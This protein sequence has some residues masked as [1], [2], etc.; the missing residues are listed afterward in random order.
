MSSRLFVGLICVALFG[1]M[2]LGCSHMKIGGSREVTKNTQ[3]RSISEIEIQQDLQRFA[4]Q[5]F[6]RNTEAADEASS[7]LGTE[8]QH[9]MLKRILLY[10]SSALDIVSGKITA[11]NLLDMMVFTTLTR[12]A[13]EH[14]FMPGMFGAAGKPLLDSLRRSELQIWRIGEGILTNDQL[15]RLRALITQWKKDNPDQYRVEMVRLSQF[16]R[17]AGNLAEKEEDDARG[18]MAGVRSATQTADAAVLLGERSMFFAQRAPF[19]FRLQARVGAYEITRDGIRQLAGQAK[20]LDRTEQLLDR[21]NTII[22]KSSTLMERTGE[23]EPMLQELSE[24]TQNATVVTREARLLNASLTPLAERLAPLLEERVDAQGKPV[25]AVESVLDSSNELSSR[26]FDLV[27]EL[28]GLL[29]NGRG[30]QRFG[31]LRSELDTELRRIFGYLALLGA[32]WATFFWGGYYLVR[33]RMDERAAR[34]PRAPGG[35]L[36]RGARPSAG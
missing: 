22:D 15:T 23:L 12:D 7:E 6:D 24:L 29:P 35:S 13:Y 32:A 36:P 30:D 9:E 4:G 10:D 2:A 31:V 16:S 25:L 3:G 5:Y 20:L 19:L 8:L 18:L 17:V 34:G 11:I 33:R 27:H 1:G 28:R 14:H 26:T 21:T